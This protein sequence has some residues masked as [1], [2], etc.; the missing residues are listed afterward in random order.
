MIFTVNPHTH[1]EGKLNQMMKDYDVHFVPLIDAGVCIADGN[2]IGMG[3]R[4]DVFL[5]NPAN[6][7][8]NYIAEVWPGKVHFVD[9]LHP[10]AS[11]FWKQQLQRLFH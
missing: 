5:K 9:F 11:S 10:N 3:Q 6:P 8:M 7:M 4:L 1:G 2:A